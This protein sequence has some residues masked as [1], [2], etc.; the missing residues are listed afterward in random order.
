MPTCKSCRWASSYPAGLPQLPRSLMHQLTVLGCSWGGQSRDRRVTSELTSQ[1]R[2]L[3][4][5]AMGQDRGQRHRCGQDSPGGT[6]E[7]G[8]KEA[9]IS[10]LQT[11]REITR[12]GRGWSGERCRGGQPD[13]KPRGTMCRSTGAGVPQSPAAVSSWGHRDAEEGG[14]G[15]PVETRER[16]TKHWGGDQEKG[17]DVG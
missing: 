14:P 16:H 15:V 5:L 10:P 1:E 7:Q 3:P 9:R 2:Q 11:P 6:P 4:T 12:V 8:L 17:Q 13:P